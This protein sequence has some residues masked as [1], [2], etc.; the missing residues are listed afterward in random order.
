MRERTY[1]GVR[2]LGVSRFT[3]SLLV[4]RYHTGALLRQN[5]PAEAPLSPPGLPVRSGDIEGMA[6]ANSRVRGAAA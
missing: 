2:S 3:V 6:A 5:L 4:L 1:S